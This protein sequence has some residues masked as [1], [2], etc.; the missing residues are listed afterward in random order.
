MM[1]NLPIHK[2]TCVLSKDVYILAKTQFST[3]LTQEYF[4][5]TADY[6]DTSIPSKTLQTQIMKPVTFVSLS[7]LHCAVNGALTHLFFFM[8]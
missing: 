2:C 3:H 5:H 7:P 4:L 1:Y 6:P 8:H